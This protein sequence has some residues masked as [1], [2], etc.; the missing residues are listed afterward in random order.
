[1]FI[2]VSTNPPRGRTDRMTMPSPPA[3]PVP[4]ARVCAS[5]GVVWKAGCWFVDVLGRGALDDEL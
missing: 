2:A 3:L 1:M 5:L 4:I